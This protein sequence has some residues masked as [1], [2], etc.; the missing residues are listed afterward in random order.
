MNAP[1][2]LIAVFDV[3]KTNAKIAFVD[4]ALGQEVWSARRANN[5]VQG[6]LLRELDVAGIEA[7]LLESLRDAPQRERV[8]AKLALP[9]D[10]PIVV[11]K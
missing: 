7:W 1:S 6:S 3:G 9:R 2:P 10:I 11:R 8:A 4:P 5:V